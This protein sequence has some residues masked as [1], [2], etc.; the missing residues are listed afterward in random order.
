MQDHCNYQITLNAE[1]AGPAE[2]LAAHETQ[3]CGKRAMDQLN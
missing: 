3:L 2:V 1:T